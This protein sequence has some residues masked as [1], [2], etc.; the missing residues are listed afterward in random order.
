MR[1]DAQEDHHTPFRQGR[2]TGLR[3]GKKYLEVADLLAGETDASINVCVGVAVLA[4]IAAADTVCAAA[5]GERYSGPDHV[6]AAALLGRVDQALGRR[7][8]RLIQLKSESQYG[9]GL[10]SA[11]DRDVALREAAALIAEAERRM[12]G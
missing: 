11:H 4:G 10:L 7:L 6:S 2:S 9:A 3:V 8:K 5:L 12:I 1:H